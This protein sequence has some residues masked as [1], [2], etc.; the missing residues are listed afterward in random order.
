MTELSANSTL[1]FLSNSMGLHGTV[2][3]HTSCA[4][5]VSMILA[6]PVLVVGSMRNYHVGC[7]ANNGTCEG[8]SCLSFK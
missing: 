5:C 3:I 1:L 6:V 8:M 7:D 2:N 4:Q